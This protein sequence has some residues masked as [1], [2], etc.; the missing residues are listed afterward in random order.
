[1]GRKKKIIDAKPDEP[2]YEFDVVTFKKT[3]EI[4]GCNKGEI[5][6]VVDL[7]HRDKDAYEVVT[8]SGDISTFKREE[9]RLATPGDV[10]RHKKSQAAKRPENFLPPFV[11]AEVD[12]VIHKDAD[13][14]KS[15]RRTS[16]IGTTPL[17][18][19]DSVRALG[20]W[21]YHSEP[22]VCRTAQ[23]RPT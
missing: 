6:T 21:S 18:K 8:Q 15:V 9:F 3:D 1:M 13:K 16:R 19:P 23:R 17:H 7:F 22:S 20:A 11:P 12:K 2:I 5:G 14:D 10:A 4:R